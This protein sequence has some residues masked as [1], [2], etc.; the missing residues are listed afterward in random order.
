MINLHMISDLVSSF[1]N[2]PQKGFLKQ[3]F[4][5]IFWKGGLIGSAKILFKNL[6]FNM[7]V[8]WPKKT[9]L[10]EIGF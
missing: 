1:G 4:L 6:I 8:K 10:G 3:L 7:V 2:D 9:F 5:F